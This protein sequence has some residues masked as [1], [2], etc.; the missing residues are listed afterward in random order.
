MNEAQVRKDSRDKRG[1]K[2]C[3]QTEETI[4]IIK[5][6]EKLINTNLP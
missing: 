4:F 5:K 2:I 1:V 6:C 3:I